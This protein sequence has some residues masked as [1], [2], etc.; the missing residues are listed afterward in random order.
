[1]RIRLPAMILVSVLGLSA[2]G[3]ASLVPSMSRPTVPSVATQADGPKTLS[4]WRREVAFP[5]FVPELV[6]TRRVTVSF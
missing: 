2:C 4:Q 5:I 6:P 1:M 3:K